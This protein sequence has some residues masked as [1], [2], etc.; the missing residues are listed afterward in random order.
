MTSHGSLGAMDG[1]VLRVGS[2]SHRVALAVDELDWRVLVGVLAVAAGVLWY[3]LGRALAVPTIFGDELI[4]A[5]AARNLAV[6]GSL[7][8]G[9]YGVV[10]PVIDAT[11]F[12]L[13]SNDVEAYR[14]I[15]A[16]NV[17]TMVCAAFIVYPLA[18]RAMSH[19]WALVVAALSLVLPW[20]TYARFVLTEPDFYPVFLLFALSVVR[21]LERPSLQQQLLM[22]A[23]LALCY[24]T[25][26][27]AVVLVGAVLV[28]IPL[29][30]IAQGHA[31]ETLRAFAP[32]WALFVAGGAVVA[33]TAVSGVWSPLGPYRPLLDEWRHPH[34]FAI[35]VAANLSAL[36]LGLGL[37]V[38][39]A[40]PLGVMMMLRRT[41]S[42]GAAALAAVSVGATAALLVSVSL[43][44]ESKFGQGSVHERDLFF[45]APLII[46]CAFAWATNGNWPQGKLAGAVTA[47]A[48]I[49]LATTIPAGTITTH[50]VDALSF[51]LWAR[52]DVAPFAPSGWIVAATAVGAVVVLTVRSAWPLLLT[53]A[54]SAVC[55]AS[56]SNYHSVASRTDADHYAWVDRAVPGS[57]SVAVLYVGA[58]PTT[59]GTGDPSPLA[60]MSLLTEF[61][62]SRVEQVG[63]LLHDNPDRVLPSERFGILPNG[64]VTG[65]GRPL[66]PQ[67]VVTDAR[68][69]IAGVRDA[70]LS[71]EAVMPKHTA[72]TA[73]LTLW[74]VH[75]PLRLLRPTQALHP[76]RPSCGPS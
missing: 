54:L 17:V 76:R 67:F 74:R 20:L 1:S 7:A 2:A 33:L 35:W 5:D 43:L 19:R 69:A 61:F 49:G 14:L 30:G 29:F 63:Y 13:S 4:H 15:Q 31:R 11:A 62:N 25:R 68:I 47:V 45:A 32:T 40:A 12:L 42:A 55:V 39:V 6:H 53:V 21:A 36:F 64:V 52:I 22:M 57:E 58:G 65:N 38:G 27:Q 75:G 18:R 72:S 9:G 3:S 44:S 46:A 48:V 73:A 37:L 23:A 66:R 70:S 28:A 16:I 34:G 24:L 51:K 60:T 50:D 10:G 56:L 8:T 26:T 41:A 71:S 59:C